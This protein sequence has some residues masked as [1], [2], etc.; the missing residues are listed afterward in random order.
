M[1]AGIPVEPLVL[2]LN[3]GIWETLSSRTGLACARGTII[4][5]SSNSCVCIGGLQGPKDIESPLDL[6]DLEQIDKSF[7][8]G[9]ADPYLLDLFV[10][11]S[12]LLLGRLYVYGADIVAILGDISLDG[13]PGLSDLIVSMVLG[14]I[15]QILIKTDLLLHLNKCMDMLGPILVSLLGDD[16]LDDVVLLL[17]VL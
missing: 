4:P 16:V 1:L 9:S 11:L 13:L 8:H 14:E 7:I 3:I 5:K 2:R 17:E 6:G 15:K 12:A 10:V